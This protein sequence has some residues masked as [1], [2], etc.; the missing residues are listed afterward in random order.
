MSNL[1]RNMQRNQQGEAHRQAEF[2]RKQEIV[3]K[4]WGNYG[5]ACFILGQAVQKPPTEL[6]EMI[7]FTATADFLMTLHRENLLPPPLL[8]GLQAIDRALKERA[9]ATAQEAGLG[10]EDSGASPDDPP[11]SP[12]GANER[13]DSES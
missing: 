7:Q 12:D 8:G 10:E 6:D 13:E 11:T 2:K 9:A 5:L 3:L 1:L 4:N